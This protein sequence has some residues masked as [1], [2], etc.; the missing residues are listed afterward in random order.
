MYLEIIECLNEVNKSVYGLPAI[1]AFI[2]ANLAEIIFVIYSNLL[3]PRDYENDP[4]MAFAF[5]RLSVPIIN[6]LTLY[7]IGQSTENEVFI[8]YYIIYYLNLL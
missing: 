2:T 1:V 8:L 6:V 5:I 7:T 3:F 4:Y